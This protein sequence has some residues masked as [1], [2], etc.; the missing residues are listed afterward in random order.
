VSY[1]NKDVN[2]T[3]LTLN[4]I[5]ENLAVTLGTTLS[6]TFLP[7]PQPAPSFTHTHARI[8]I[9]SSL[10][11]SLAF[12]RA[13]SALFIRAH[14]AHPG[15]YHKAAMLGAVLLKAFSTFSAASVLVHA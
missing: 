14:V 4:V 2:G 6:K 10:R 11:Y 5:T 1:N 3:E 12:A 9:R 8:V 7:F 13:R 15:C